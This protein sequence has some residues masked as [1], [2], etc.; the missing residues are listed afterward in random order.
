MDLPET[1]PARLYLLAYDPAKGRAR[2]R[3]RIGYVLRAA[4]LADLYL[5]GNL[6]DADGRPRASARAPLPAD[7]VLDAVLRDIAESRPR[8]WAHW[9][10]KHSEETKRAVVDQLAAG[11]W[12]EVHPRRTLG[13]IPSTTVTLHE[14]AVVSRLGELFRAALRATAAVTDAGQRDA[15]MV[16]LAAAGG[17]S[18]VLPEEQRHEHGTQAGPV[19]TALRRVL[20]DGEG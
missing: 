16:A 9:V 12:I 1:L 17:L 18:T 6:E 7:P 2:P 4:A 3:S 10:R 11:G 19:I 13:V 20:A 8:P 14:P 15:T 5:R